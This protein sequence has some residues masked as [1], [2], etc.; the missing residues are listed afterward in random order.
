M[1]LLMLVLLGLTMVTCSY[2]TLKEGSRSTTFTDDA[3]VVLKSTLAG[4]IKH[5]ERPDQNTEDM[6]TH[7]CVHGADKLWAFS[8]GMPETGLDSGSYWPFSETAVLPCEFQGDD[9]LQDAL[10]AVIGKGNSWAVKA[11]KVSLRWCDGSWN[12]HNE[13]MNK[14]R[15][16]LSDGAVVTCGVSAYIP[17]K[18]GMAPFLLDYEWESTTI[19]KSCPTFLSAIGS[20][21]AYLWG[22]ELFT[23]LVL[24]GL[25]IG[26][27][28][29]R[30]SPSLLNKKEATLGRLLRGAHNDAVCHDVME[31]KRQMHE[32]QL[33]KMEI[34]GNEAD[35]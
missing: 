7:I 8:I 30:A 3:V 2:N 26:L 24:G 35:E 18:Y 29:V 11:G 23:T 27:G 13:A 10:E 15:R 22:V 4:Q 28:C 21:S 14:A 32:L 34:Q 12:R 6:T 16:E 20:T 1:A 19:T 25:A 17:T 31:L 33:F 5:F 9:G